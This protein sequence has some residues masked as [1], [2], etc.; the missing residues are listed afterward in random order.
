[1]KNQTPPLATEF[2]AKTRSR[3]LIRL[4]H[5]TFDLLI[6]GGGIT[7]AG[8]AS[9]ATRRGYKVALVEKG[10]F[11]SGTSSKSSK[12]IH[13]GLRYL[14]TL[15]FGQ[16]FEACHQ[17]HRLL[18]LAPHLVC[19]LPFVLPVYQNSPRPWWQIRVA[20]WLYDVL[21]TSRNGSGRLWPGHQIWSADQVV[22]NEPLL[23]SEGLLKAAHYYE[24][25]ADDA[26]LTLMTL[27][28][29]HRLG[30]VLANHTMVT[31]LL[32]AGNRVVGVQVCDQLSSSEIEVEAPLV[33]SAVGPW[34]DQLLRL[35]AEPVQRWLHPTK[36]VHLVVRRER[37]PTQAALTFNAPHDG[38]FM[39]LTPWG[40]HTLIGT[41][42]TNYSRDPDNVSATSEDVAYILEAVEKAFP[43]AR[44][45]ED[46]V[47]STYAGLRP[48]VRENGHSRGHTPSRSNYS[49]SREHRVCQVRPGLITVAGGK[50]TTYRTMAKEVVNEAARIL[51]LEHHRSPRGVRHHAYP[52]LPGG[53]VNDWTAYQTQQRATLAA[54]TGLPE[55]IAGYLVATYGTEVGHLLTLLL[56]RPTLAKRITPELSVIKAQIIHAIR[57][58]MA[59]TLEDVLNRRT[60]MMSCAADQGLDVA[61]AVAS[62]MAVELGWSLK[63]RVAQVEDYRH[64]VA[65]SRRWQNGG[66]QVC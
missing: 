60:P 5:E 63:E 43:S 16:V 18:D 28:D 2:S 53:N 19:P 29:A 56:R 6:I 25:G 49:R 14:A 26:R 22:T 65:M 21:T 17:R 55:E 62:W 32:Q 11:A 52:A 35:T 20:M 44:L 42:D 64:K 31:G 39:F 3:N 15:K 27:L 61:E 37:L 48:L 38:R 46:D 24:C 58:E 54:E 12:L 13:G 47:V 59:L 4:E 1:M 8:I 9:E 51:A 45:N 10:D 41:T 57:H 40:G 34:T 50:F 30:A 66:S 23:S 36:G 7:G 33:I